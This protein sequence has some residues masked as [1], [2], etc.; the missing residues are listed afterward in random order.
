MRSDTHAIK[1]MVQGAAKEL[2]M[3][4]EMPEQEAETIAEAC[5]TAVA[6]GIGM[7]NENLV[8]KEYLDARFAEADAKNEKRANRITGQITNRM[9][10]SIGIATA[11]LG[12]M[13]TFG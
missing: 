4:R 13:I 3:A 9:T 8:T 12:L 5:A 11:L 2:L 1:L 7:N 6:E 10:L